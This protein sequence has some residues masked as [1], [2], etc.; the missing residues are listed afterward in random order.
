MPLAR[1]C[2]L[3][4]KYHDA[5]ND[6]RKTTSGKQGHAAF[7][8]YQPSA[9]CAGQ[10]FSSPCLNVFSFCSFTFGLEHI[11]LLNGYIVDATSSLWVT[12]R[13]GSQ[14]DQ[15]MCAICRFYLQAD[16]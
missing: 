8:A 15:D 1:T 13:L 16:V 12:V 5:F 11:R 10:Q 7:P 3:I 9:E 2:A 4:A 6:V 14:A